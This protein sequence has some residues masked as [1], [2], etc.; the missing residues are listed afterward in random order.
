MSVFSDY[1]KVCV[2]LLL[3]SLTMSAGGN[4]KNVLGADLVPCCLDP[5]TGWYRDGFCKTDN[6]D[7]GVHTVCAR[8]T[9][10]FLQYTKLRGNDLSS[11]HP[12]SFPGL[13]AGDN[14]CL[15]VSRWKEAFMEGVAPPVI[16]EATNQKSLNIVN[17]PDL[18]SLAMPSDHT[19]L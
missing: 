7:F 17:L 5:I 2:F 9:D 4:Q 18:K 8:M 12:P 3:Q 19:E 11:A 14:W 16:L 1:F 10:Q 15:C 13:K 6:R